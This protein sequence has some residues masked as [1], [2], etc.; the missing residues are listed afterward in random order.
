MP[1]NAE[2]TIGFYTRNEELTNT[3]T[4]AAGVLLAIVG[5]FLLLQRTSSTGDIWK[6]VTCAIFGASLIISYTFSMLYHGMR[7]KKW[8]YWMRV[9]DHAGVYFL[10]AGTYT[11]FTLI[12]IGGALGWALF[13]VVWV[14]AII[15]ITLKFVKYEIPRSASAV[16]YLVM[17][18]IS[19]FAFK[20]L[21]DFAETSG[22]GG[23]IL[24]TSGGVLYS[25]GTIFYS[26]KGLLF[27]HAI[28]HIFVLA[29]SITHYFAVLLYVIPFTS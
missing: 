13:T 28:W 10:I 29:G 24:L 22:W 11:P 21:L 15:G 25:V 5:L 7:N 8:K 14:I 17:G 23:L 4:H 18:W 6:I 20:P 2:R 19:L 1:E 27:N 16:P 12:V 9:I 26:W 3:L